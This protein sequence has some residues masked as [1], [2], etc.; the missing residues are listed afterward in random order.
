MGRTKTK[1]F[2]FEILKKSVKLQKNI[3]SEVNLT[4]FSV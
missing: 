2:I 4:V 1:T 3:I